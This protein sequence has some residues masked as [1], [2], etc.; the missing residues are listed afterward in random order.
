MLL[1]SSGTSKSKAIRNQGYC[2]QNATFSCVGTHLQWIHFL[3]LIR[4]F[5]ILWQRWLLDKPQVQKNQQRLTSSSQ[6][7]T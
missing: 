4:F 6:C 2:L 5:H 3:P 1:V 7:Q